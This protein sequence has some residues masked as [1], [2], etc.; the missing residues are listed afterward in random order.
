MD[1]VIAQVNGMPRSTEVNQALVTLSALTTIVQGA[2]S[3]PGRKVIVLLSEGFRLDTEGG[4]ID[5]R[6]RGTL[7]RLYDQAARA[8]WSSTRSTCADSDRL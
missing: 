7:E 5:A 1:A 8:A 3:L 2:R 4:F 6:I